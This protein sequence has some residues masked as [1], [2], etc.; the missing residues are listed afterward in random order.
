MKKII[1]YIAGNKWSHLFLGIIVLV[2]GV[3]EVK[4]TFVDD[5]STGTLRAGHG[6]VLIGVF[7]FL[8]ALGEFVDSLDY[9]KE[10]LD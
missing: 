5:F 1:F 9:I 8:K 10:G 4:D 6:V 7:H 2:S 3:I